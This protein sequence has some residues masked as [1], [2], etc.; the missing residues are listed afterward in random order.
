MVAETVKLEQLQKVS[1]DK[2]KENFSRN[3]ED[4][5]P[6][7]Q[8]GELFFLVFFFVFFCF[9]VFFFSFDVAVTFFQMRAI[10]WPD[11]VLDTC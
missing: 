3:K 1:S 8:N 6:K 10:D 11:V 7:C 4:L 9:F 5:N 2:N